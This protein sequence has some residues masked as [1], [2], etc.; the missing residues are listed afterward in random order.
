LYEE[1][2]WVYVISSRPLVGRVGVGGDLKK[3]LTTFARKLRQDPSD[4]EKYL[5]RK[6]RGN[7]LGVKF[8]RQAVIGRYIV[9]FACFEKK[10]VVE[11]D[12]GQHC[13]SQQDMARDAW[14][15]SQGFKVLRFWN[16]DVLGNRD[17]VLEEIEKYLKNSPSYILPASGRRKR[18][19]LDAPPY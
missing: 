12:G 16:N 15:S 9:D 19:R 18:R 13:Q 2:E 14:L 17:G 4:A 7:N 8:L 1:K 11:V 10:V 5:W 6:L 3:M